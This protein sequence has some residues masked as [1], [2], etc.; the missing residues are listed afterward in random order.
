MDYQPGDA[1]DRILD[2]ENALRILSEHQ[3]AEHRDEQ[4]EAPADAGNSGNSEPPADSE[5]SEEAALEQALPEFRDGEIVDGTVVQVD[6]DSVIVDVGA[7]YE[8]AIPRIEFPNPNEIPKVGDKLSVAVVRVNDDEG[9]LELS[10]KRADYEN[11]WRRIL[12]AHANGTVV[13]AMVTERVKGGLRVDLGVPGFVPASQVAGGLRS[14]DRFVGR[15]LRLRVIEADRRQK[16]VIASHRLVVEEERARRKTE[17]LGRLFEGAI[18]EGK[19][20]NLT[21]YGAFIDLGGVDGLL[22]VSEMSWSRVKHPSDVLKVGDTIQV[23]VLKLDREAERISLGRRQILPDPWKVTAKSL[24]V[25][26]LVHGRITRVVR[27]GAFAQ[28]GE[29]VEGFIPVSELAE[30]RVN[31]PSDVVAVDQEMDL[32]ILSIRLEERRMTLSLTQAQQAKERE[33]YRQYI[34]EQKRDRA[35]LGDVFGDVLSRVRDAAEQAQAQ[36]AATQ[37][38]QQSSPA[39]AESAGEPPSEAPATE[40]AEQQSTA[41]EEKSSAADTPGAQKAEEQS[42]AAEEK[43]AD[44]A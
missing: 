19:V 34:E 17:T 39:A 5:A 38:D 30:G 15:S 35:T 2:K 12:D 7:K 37:G 24:K 6:P 29:G 43:P 11:V 31:D 32:K 16:K 41:P 44:Q 42:T 28:V 8:G 26:Q 36:T 21:D 4:E 25:G 27:N 3:S 33:E 23:M 10:K 13:T 9:L 40:Q 20:R 18:C 22:H 1:L 14:L